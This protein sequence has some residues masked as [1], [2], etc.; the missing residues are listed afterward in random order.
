MIRIFRLS[1]VVLTAL[2]G[3]LFVRCELPYE[4]DEISL[5]EE[6]NAPVQTGS[7]R[8][9]EINKG[10]QI[11]NPSISRDTENYPGCMLWLG[12]S[13]ELNVDTSLVSGYSIP[14][15]EH[16]RL[17]VSD[18]ANRVRWFIKNTDI[19]M[20]RSDHLQDPEWSTHS[21]YIAF[22]AENQSGY[23][24][25]TVRVSDKEYIRITENILKS[26]ATP[27]LYIPDTAISQGSITSPEYYENGFIKKEYIE[28]FFGTD[29]VKF[30]YSEHTNGRT[31]FCID[32][33]EENP[34][35]FSLNKPEGKEEWDCGSAMVSDQGNWV[36]YNCETLGEQIPFMQ[37]LS[38][39]SVPE[40]IADKGYAPRW[41]RDPNTD[42]S[43][44]V[45]TILES[46]YFITADLTAETALKGGEGRT[47]KVRL[48]GTL[49][50]IPVH[51]GPGITDQ[52]KEIC[53]LP[54]KGGMSD[55]GEF[56]CT[57]YSR[58]YIVRLF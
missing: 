41:W 27:H 53:P 49:G 32:Y 46:G 10:Q 3:F 47:L 48:S 6:E 39:T 17:T 43:Y 52:V 56:I 33:S 29:N 35:P 12:F 58:G 5:P 9:Y 57:G 1:G 44:V 25:M 2:I 55:K 51:M 19:G 34:E 7:F 20:D 31:I 18:T 16:D 30:V 54:L 15:R 42:D 22:L 26:S 24:G 50:D 38:K 11:C 40:R 37:K 45:Y 13:G 21:D 14:A 8:V 36:V 28:S 4:P 23:H